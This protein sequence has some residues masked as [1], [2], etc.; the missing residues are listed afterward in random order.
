MHV[1]DIDRVHIYVAYT[2]AME[3]EE[4]QHGQGLPE[5]HEFVGVGPHMFQT[6]VV[7]LEVHER[8]H[9]AKLRVR[10]AVPWC[11]VHDPTTWFGAA[12]TRVTSSVGL[13]QHERCAAVYRFLRDLT[14]PKDPM[15]Y[16]R[17]FR[18][19]ITPWSPAEQQ[20]YRGEFALL[21]TAYRHEPHVRALADAALASEIRDAGRRPH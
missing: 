10:P 15:A 7:G 13:A 16:L 21:A 6:Q 11:V 9:V 20:L 12:V 3:T 1:L 19:M 4:G 2:P 8:R 5:A 17:C 18:D 14:V